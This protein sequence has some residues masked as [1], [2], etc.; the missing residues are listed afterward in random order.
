M[1]VGCWLPEMIRMSKMFIRQS[2]DEAITQYV[3]EVTIDPELTL[4][5]IYNFL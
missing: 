2:R 3:T 1:H 4:V 5:F